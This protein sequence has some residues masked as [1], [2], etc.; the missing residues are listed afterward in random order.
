MIFNFGDVLQGRARGF[1]PHQLSFLQSVVVVGERSI[2]RNKLFV[3][4]MI[5]A[6]EYNKVLHLL[7]GDAGYERLKY[8]LENFSSWSEL[9]KP[10][11]FRKWQGDVDYFPELCAVE[12]ESR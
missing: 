12:I 11:M 9:T 10:E 6:K 5:K 1:L 7:T 4:E 2:A 3:S 8:L